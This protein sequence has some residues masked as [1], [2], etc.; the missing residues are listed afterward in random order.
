[1]THTHNTVSTHSTLKTE[2]LSELFL[3]GSLSYLFLLLRWIRLL[4]E[5][6]CFFDYSTSRFPQTT[7]SY[8]TV[9]CGLPGLNG[10]VCINILFNRS[11]LA[12]VQLQYPTLAFSALIMRWSKI[13]SRRVLLMV[14][15]C[16]VIWYLLHSLGYQDFCYLKFWL[17]DSFYSIPGRWILRL[18]HPWKHFW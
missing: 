16:L 18:L 6:S 2:L 15:S 7:R 14:L 9:F 13:S 4:C 8:L 3:T 11:S 10:F 17:R 12:D 5:L 1:M